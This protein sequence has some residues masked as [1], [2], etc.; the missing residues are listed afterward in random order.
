MKCNMRCNI[1]CLVYFNY[2]YF[3]FSCC[4]HHSKFYLRYAGS[5][6]MLQVCVEKAV[7]M[8]SVGHAFKDRDFA[9][10]FTKKRKGI[11]CF[12]SLDH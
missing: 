2:H 4:L 5:S 1:N 7:L 9:L 3:D 12:G 8:F 10:M 11:T 6:V